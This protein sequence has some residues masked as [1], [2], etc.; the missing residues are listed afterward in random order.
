MS[1]GVDSSVCAYLS[2][3]EGFGCTGVTLKLFEKEQAAA[4][5]NDIEDARRVAEKLGISHRV[6]DL[7]ELFRKRVIDP[8]VQS[9]R[10]GQ[11]PNPCIECNKH[12]KF[13]ALLD[14]A[15]QMGCDTVVTGHYAVVEKDTHGERYLL[16]KAA[17]A[18]K[19]Q[20]YVLY[21]LTQRQLKHVRF[22]LGPLTKAETRAIAEEQGL[23]TAHKSD[24]QDIC[25][26]P[27]GDY[28]A[29]IEAFTGQAFP[30]GRFV[31]PDGDVLGRHRGIIRYTVGQRRGLGLALPAPLYVMKKDVA[32]NDVVLCRNEEL[33]SDSLDAG[34]V[35]FIPFDTLA[36][37]LRVHA[38][39]R[40]RHQEQPATITPGENGTVHVV[41]DQPQRAVTPGQAVVFYDGDTVLGGGTI[42]SPE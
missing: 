37:P 20:S 42:L 10:D 7:T 39:I 15:A 5:A 28:A 27:A 24:S 32:N 34:N 12:L 25:F 22:P 17:D 1:G 16:K 8:F 9:Y 4:N 2:M 35:N 29:F 26:V 38:K 36:G 23:V 11:T 14:I 21:G 6:A 31:T 13:G 40:Y 3:Q 18:S 41:F 33:F 19:D 30:E